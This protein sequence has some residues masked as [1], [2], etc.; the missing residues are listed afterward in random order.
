MTIHF[1]LN[2]H[3]LVNDVK[4]FRTVS[5]VCT[6]NNASFLGQN[7]FPSPGS[8]LTKQLSIHADYLV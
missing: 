8:P 3:L 1:F 7:R 4:T 2:V 6:E 5:T